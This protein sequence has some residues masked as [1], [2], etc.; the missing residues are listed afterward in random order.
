MRIFG[1]ARRKPT[2]PDANFPGLSRGKAH[3]LRSEL[4]KAA[5]ERG[6]SV[7]ITGRTLVVDHPRLGRVKT[8][9]TG[10][11]RALTSNVHPKAAQRIAQKLVDQML[12]TPLGRGSKTANV[13]AS[14][15]PRLVPVR[16]GEGTFTRD[17]TEAMV[18]DTGEGFKTMSDD[19]LSRIDDPA[20]LRHAAHVNLRA[21]IESTYDVQVSDKAGGVV[22]IEAVGSELASAAVDLE[23]VLDTFAPRIDRSRGLLFSLPSHACILVAPVVEGEELV[24]ALNTLAKTAVTYPTTQPVSRLV[25]LWH[26]GEVET[27]SSFDVEAQAVVI[28][29]NAYLTGLLGIDRDSEG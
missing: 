29:P 28:T 1:R 15:R 3:A 18:L 17:T 5:G 4:R 20:T 16:D 24:A 2:E 13:Y 11:V 25:H 12:A 8:D 22:A 26:N 6:A 23:M 27:L 9:I 7:R 19:E 21:D 14:L 10:A